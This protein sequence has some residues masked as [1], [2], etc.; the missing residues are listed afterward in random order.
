MT[1]KKEE[2]KKK[3]FD[4]YRGTLKEGR[5]TS[6]PLVIR[7]QPKVFVGGDK[8]E[9][10]SELVVKRMNNIERKKK[11]TRESAIFASNL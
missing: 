5:R 9:I 1:F 10:E 8:H 3:S 11:K 4:Q 2:K 6:E 7:F